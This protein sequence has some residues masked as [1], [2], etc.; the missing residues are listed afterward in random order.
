MRTWPDH[1]AEVGQRMSLDYE[2]E[3]GA[4][5]I[6]VEMIQDSLVITIPYEGPWP[7]LLLWVNGLY[8]HA[9]SADLLGF[10][11]IPFIAILHAILWLLF[12]ALKVPRPPLLWVSV[13]PREVHIEA[14]NRET[15]TVERHCWAREKVA[16][17]RSN[18]FEPDS[19]WVRADGLMAAD[20]I[21]GLPLL[22]LSEL[23]RQLARVGLGSQP[24]S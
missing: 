11:L 23:D 16:E 10:L 12:N 9:G 7:R 24:A 5:G 20:V 19:L 1:R 4:G 14:L 8:S 3:P 17:L 6:S 18:R 21:R 22:T 13:G 2:P 15:G